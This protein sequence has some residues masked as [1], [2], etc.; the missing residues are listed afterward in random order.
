MAKLKLK[1]KTE[2]RI[3]KKG[4]ETVYEKMLGGEISQ[5]DRFFEENV[6]YKIFVVSIVLRCNLKLDDFIYRKC[7][8]FWT[9]LLIYNE[10]CE[11]GQIIVNET[12]L[13]SF[14]CLIRLLVYHY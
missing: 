10:F 14:Y 9:L 12:M 7:E 1:V 8:W 5:K 11:Y 3:K 4:I 6:Q 13:I 2:R